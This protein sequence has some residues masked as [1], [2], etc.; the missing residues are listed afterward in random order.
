[1]NHVCILGG[2]PAGSSAALAARREGADVRIIERSRLPRH[3]VC[4]EFLSPGIS[5]ALE[6]L[7]L[8]SAF[9]DLKPA[10]IRRM[11]LRVGS[12]EKSET[13]PET[14]YGLSRYTFDSW[15]WQTAITCGAQ[16]VTAGTAN[17][18]TSGRAS[19]RSRGGRLFGFK[20][21]FNGP[22][23]DAV[24]LYFA[25]ATYVG[26]NCVENGVTNVCGLAPEEQLRR[27]AF[28]V[29]TMIFRD[30]AT[31]ARLAPLTR[32]WDWI[33]TGP[34]EFGNRFNAI[35]EAYVAGD[36]LSFIDPFTGSGLLCAVLT[37][38]LAGES[39][40]RSAPVDEYVQQCSSLLKQSFGFSSI[41]R[42]IAS[43]RAAGPLLQVM[44]ANLIFR[45]TRP[46][47][48]PS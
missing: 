42:R 31:R 14:A 12:A 36:A 27:H 18:I 6:R 35:H 19:T 20:A 8:W 39:A 1:V 16:P 22:A 15:L 24:E 11:L 28:D 10:L 41:L 21:H 29:D 40:A 33:F 48:S 46:S 44:P 45:L 26:V 25:G 5:Q 32:A 2:G 23:D 7:G 47:R 3:K 4:G 9:C 13:L 17:I 34:L 37:G 43:T 38:S 30:A